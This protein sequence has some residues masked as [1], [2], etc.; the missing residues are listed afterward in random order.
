MTSVDTDQRE[1][2]PTRAGEDLD[3]PTLEAWLRAHIDD[4]PDTAMTVEQFP[5][6]AANLTYRLSFGPL[7]LVLRR[8][9][10]GKI[11]PGAHDMA[12]EYA[13]LSKLWRA[14]SCAPRAFAFCEDDSIIGAPFVVQEYRAGGIVIFG[15]A[16]PDM[17]EL[18]DLGLR[19]TRAMARA[20]ADLH[21]V[22][23]HTHQL[24]DLG[25]PEG[26][27]ERQLSGW[28]DRWARVAASADPTCGVRYEQVAERLAAT[29][30]QSGPAAIIHNDYK[31]DNCQ[32][33]PNAP[34]KV[35]SVFDWDM[36]TLGDPLVDVGICL[37]YWPHMRR[38]QSLGLPASKVFAECYA[39]YT[40]IDV[41]Q[42]RWYETFAHWR[43]GVAV[44][45]LYDRYTKGNSA[46]NRYASMGQAVITMIERAETVLAGDDL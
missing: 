45:Q 24:G 40:G 35:V 1:T 21:Q 7:Q 43:T 22:D 11:A 26:F 27:L 13:I 14:W 39:D 6:G 31:L 9:P 19:L 23:Y 25:K 28:R 2:A 37:S 17:A 8:P 5:R 29:M 44:Q 18:P 16:P 38:E 36:A 10:F 20:L 42:M 33:L 46:D 3:W 41:N 32:F 30:P 4:L 15:K 12:R 34:D